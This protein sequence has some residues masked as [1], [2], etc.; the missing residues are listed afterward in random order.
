[1]LEACFFFVWLGMT[2]KV[3]EK[4]HITDHLLSW[5]SGA[6]EFHITDHL[7]S[8][9]SGPETTNNLSRP[10]TWM[11]HIAITVLAG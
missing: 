1:M 4:F 11:S 3:S 9:A 6:C 8:W 10:F 2:P 7:P 5:A